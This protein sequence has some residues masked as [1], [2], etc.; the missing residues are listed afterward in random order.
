[1]ELRRGRTATAKV[2]EALQPPPPR[3][4]RKAPAKR[5]HRPKK[6]PAR[7][8]SRPPPT[9]LASHGVKV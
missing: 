5:D 6:L 3:R 7:L 8:A 4:R 9:P 2:Q 1:M